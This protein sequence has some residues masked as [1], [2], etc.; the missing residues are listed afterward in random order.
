MMRNLLLLPL[1]PDLLSCGVRDGQAGQSEHTLLSEA[2][3]AFRGM[4]ALR[5]KLARLFSGSHLYFTTQM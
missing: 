5:S 2:D 3:P 4:H 1:M